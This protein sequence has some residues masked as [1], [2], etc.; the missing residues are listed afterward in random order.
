MATFLELCQEVHRTIRAGALAPGSAPTAVTGQSGIEDEIVRWVKRGWVEVQQSRREWGFMVKPVTFVLA[1][2]ASTVSAS[3]VDSNYAWL[4]P[5][6][7]LRSGPHVLVYATSD[8]IG[9]EGPCWFIPYEMWRGS[10]VYDLGTRPVGRPSFFTVRPDRTLQFHSVADQEYTVRADVR[11]RAQVL[12]AD[13]D[14]PENW[15]SAGQGLLPEF[16]DV[17]VWRA[18]MYYCQSRE[19]ADKL[20]ATAQAEYRRLFKLLCNHYLPAPLLDLGYS[21]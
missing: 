12:S 15:P 17:I 21:Q 5:F 11:V 1:A 8:G 18:V 13:T 7:P 3:T 14:T 19:G 20:Y 10:A 16:H 4:L 2:S 6:T 9:A